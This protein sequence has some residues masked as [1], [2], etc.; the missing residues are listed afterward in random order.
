MI[1]NEIVIMIPINT[2]LVGIEMVVMEGHDE[3]TLSPGIIVIL[4]V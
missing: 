3:N 2:T 1:D 4:L